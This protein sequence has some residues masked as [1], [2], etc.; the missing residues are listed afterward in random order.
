MVVGRMQG[1]LPHDG[2]GWVDECLLIFTDI[3]VYV[4]FGW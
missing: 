3:P 4:E 1:F 2:I